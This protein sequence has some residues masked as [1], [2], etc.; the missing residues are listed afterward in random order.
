MERKILII[1]YHFLPL[2]T[3]G[4]FRIHDWAKY[5]KRF[6]WYPIILTRHWSPATKYPWETNEST[7]SREV[8]QDIKCLVYRTRY[9]QA[10][11]SIWNLRARLTEDKSPSR[12]KA[13]F[14]KMLSYMLRNFL[15]LP[16]EYI[17]WR[18]TAYKAGC[19]I[20]NEHHIDAILATGMPWTSFLVANDLSRKNKVP[21]VADYR[22]PWTQPTTLGIKKEYAVVFM[23]NRLLEKRIMKQ[24]SSLIHISEP[25]QKGLRKYLNLDVHLIPNG[26][27]P[28]LFAGFRSCKPGRSVFFISFV[29]TLHTNTNPYVFLEGFRYFVEQFSLSPE[30]CRLS[31]TGSG[32]WHLEKEYRF[33]GD[34][35]PLVNFEGNLSHE[36]ALKRMHKAH[37]LLSFPLDMDGCIPAKTYEYIASGRPIL[38]SPDGKY[39]GAIR[40]LLEMTKAGIILNSPKEISSWLGIKYREFQKTGEVRSCA[41]MKAVD[42][43]SREK[44]TEKLASILNVLSR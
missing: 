36:E 42:K 32:F 40:N 33:F 16:D 12:V 8:A 13:A 30:T 1:A 10:Y 19:D 37:V 11:Q 5:L 20:M 23:R 21:W 3:A 38:V 15:L 26:Y 14:R 44:Q 18:S 39:R 6:G 2:T 28:D 7:L 22:D 4:S 35:R 27:D 31:F 41:G 34:I 29:G 25:L 9:K 43:F 17:G 24:A